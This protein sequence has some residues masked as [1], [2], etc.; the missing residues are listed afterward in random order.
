MFI[1]TDD[2]LGRTCMVVLKI[3]INNNQLVYVKILNMENKKIK[4]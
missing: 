2:E 4:N 1:S 3:T